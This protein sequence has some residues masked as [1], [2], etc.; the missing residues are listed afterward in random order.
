MAPV[1]FRVI[2]VAGAA[3]LD[4]VEDCFP[5]G[6]LIALDEQE[7]VRFPVPVLFLPGDVLRGLPL[8]VD[9]VGGDHGVVQVYGVQ[10]FPDLG[11]L[12]GFIRDPVLG[13]DH[14]LLVQHRGEQLDLPVQGRR[15]AISRRSRSR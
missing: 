5:E 15:G 9:G 11:G 6:R 7:V 4:R 12:G 1:Q 2:G 10:Q 8:C 13:D 3:L 14:L